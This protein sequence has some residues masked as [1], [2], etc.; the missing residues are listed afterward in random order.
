MRRR[1]F[2]VAVLLILVLAVFGVGNAGDSSDIQLGNDSVQFVFD[3]RS[4]GGLISI[5]DKTTGV[6]FHND[7][8]VSPQ[9]FRLTL[10]GRMG[11]GEW[12]HQENGG[13]WGQT[14]EENGVYH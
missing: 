1:L 2:T 10:L 6:E 13:E 8:A 3:E 11:S 9:L 5:F 4:N 7:T 12:G 14:L